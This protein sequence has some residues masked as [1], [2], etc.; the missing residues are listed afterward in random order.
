MIYFLWGEGKRKELRGRE[1]DREIFLLGLSERSLTGGFIQKTNVVFFLIKVYFIVFAISVKLCWRSNN[2]DVYTVIL[3][4]IRELWKSTNSPWNQR[5][6]LFL[7][8]TAVSI[9]N[10]GLI[11]LLHCCLISILDRGSL[12]R[13]KVLTVQSEWQAGSFSK[14]TS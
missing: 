11:Y 14:H 6:S 9:L 3:D 7:H 4:Y 12:G 5:Y 8:L 1:R 13:E 10:I 2:T